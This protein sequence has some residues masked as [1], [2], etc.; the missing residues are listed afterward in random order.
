MAYNRSMNQSFT[1]AESP[2]SQ[3]PERSDRRTLFIGIGAG[4]VVLALAAVTFFLVRTG[5][6]PGLAPE[7]PFHYFALTGGGGESLALSGGV[8]E[9]VPIEGIEGTV[10]EHMARSGTE[11]AIVRHEAEGDTPP[12]SDIYLVGNDT[13][14]TADGLPKAA[15]AISHDGSKIAYSYLA[16]AAD[17]DTPK[18]SLIQHLPDPGV[19]VS[20]LIDVAT[21]EPRELGAGYGVQFPDPEN[22]NVVLF[23]SRE[24]IEVFDLE[25]GYS[26]IDVHQVIDPFVPLTGGIN[27]PKVSPDGAYLAYFDTTASQYSVYAIDALFPSLTLTS[28][29]N[30]PDTALDAAFS[31]NTL[32]ALVRAGE[33]LELRSYNLDAIEQPG[34]TE[35]VLPAGSFVIRIIPQR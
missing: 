29:G 14:L 22:A 16:V 11:V 27:A 18:R 28:V 6:L 26:G 35:S 25:T 2:Q 10:V 32:Y 15:L 12:R 34:R 5:D 3:G 8:L 1:D 23:L 7:G 17:A 24:G 13:P 19:W 30:V 4:I 31:G 20:V 21:G 33:V 9:P